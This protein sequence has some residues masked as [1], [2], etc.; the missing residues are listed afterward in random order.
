MCRAAARPRDPRVAGDDL[1]PES[2]ERVAMRTTRLIDRRGLEDDQ[3][4]PA[5]RSGLVIGDEASVGRWSLT[6]V[7]WWAVETIR[8]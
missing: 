1:L 8:F 7:V 3:A 4:R 5:T 6:S 2:G